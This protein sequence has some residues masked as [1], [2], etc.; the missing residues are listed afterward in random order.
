MEIILFH[1]SLCFKLFQPSSECQISAGPVA[2]R[3]P[4]GSTDHYVTVFL[5][6]H[7]GHERLSSPSAL[8]FHYR[9]FEN[10]CSRRRNEWSVPTKSNVRLKT[11]SAVS[12]LFNCLAVHICWSCDRTTNRLYTWGACVPSGIPLQ[13]EHTKKLLQ[14]SWKWEK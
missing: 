7:N 6:T 11:D 8:M 3:R 1:I 13:E 4:P 14:I 9:V 10:G 2:A 5:Q 12:S